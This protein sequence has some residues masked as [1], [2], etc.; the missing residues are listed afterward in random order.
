MS[1]E[2]Y[3]AP[4]ITDDEPET[5]HIQDSEGPG[6]LNETDYKAGV[7]FGYEDFSADSDLSDLNSDPRDTGIGET[8]ELVPARKNGKT[9]KVK[10]LTKDEESRLYTTFVMTE[11]AQRFILLEAFERK[12]HK[13]VKMD[14]FETYAQDRLGLSY[15]ASRLSKIVAAAKVERAI[16]GQQYN[17]LQ[18]EAPVSSP[19]LITEQVGIEL[20]RLPEE[21]WNL[22]Y[23]EASALPGF[24]KLTKAEQLSNLHKIV[25]REYRE[26]NPDAPKPGRK[27]KGDDS[28]PA[29]KAE[30]REAANF[31]PVVPATYDG[32]EEQQEA[33]YGAD[34]PVREWSEVDYRLTTAESFIKAFIAAMEEGPGGE[35]KLMELY[36]DCTLYQVKYGL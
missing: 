7:D 36:N 21:K 27:P 19:R 25:N 16:T 32:S 4:T 30:R 1:Y 5:D 33:E 12:A 22:V 9:P 2:E 26:L 8:A 11:K 34:G 18:I 29:I 3:D 13:A 10:D 20:N 15:S 17:V 24:D 31:T 28:P 35:L 23:E 6:P 14:S